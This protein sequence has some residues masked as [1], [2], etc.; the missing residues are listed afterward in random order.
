M[1]FAVGG[2]IVAFVCQN[3]HRIMTEAEIQPLPEKGLMERVSPG[4]PM[5]YGEC[6]SCG[7]LV[8]PLDLTETGH[9]A[10]RRILRT[11]ETDCGARSMDDE[12]DRQVTAAILAKVLEHYRSLQ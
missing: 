6:F 11:L 9:L 5:P 2:K 7:A 12:A 8:H 4:E 1:E 3:C 10:A